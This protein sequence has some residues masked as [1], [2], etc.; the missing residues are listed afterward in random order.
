L[1]AP[2]EEGGA[3]PLQNNIAQPSDFMTGA[4][5]Q[6]TSRESDPF[7]PLGQ[8]RQN[9]MIVPQQSFVTA[10]SSNS[11]QATELDSFTLPSFQ[12]T[13]PTYLSH[14]DTQTETSMSLQDN[15][16]DTDTPKFSHAEPFST[17]LSSDEE[18]LFDY[19]SG[20]NAILRAMGGPFDEAL[21]RWA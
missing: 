14:H 16:V 5:S 15:D 12:G 3:L 2:A 10:P 4:Y 19:D 13:S 8:Y 6:P 17:G 9:P 20:F 1:T 18:G 7:D 21:H 11:H